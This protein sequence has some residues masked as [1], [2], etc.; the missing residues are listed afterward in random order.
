MVKATNGKSDFVPDGVSINV[1]VI[2]QL[3][4]SL[5]SSL[6]NVELHIGCEMT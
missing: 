6:V 3:Q 4:S 1:K 2:T 5:E